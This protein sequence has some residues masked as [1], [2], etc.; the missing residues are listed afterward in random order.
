[1]NAIALLLTLL[2]AGNTGSSCL[3]FLKLGQG[4]RGA[5]LGES[6]TSLAEDA[7]A[8]YWNP[9]GLAR[10][11]GY[12]F[13]A[14]HQQWF[15]GITDEVG[16]AAIP[17]GPGALGF[18]LVYSGD[19]GF[20]GWTEENEPTGTF[21]T[22]S[23]AL[24]AGYGLTV[25]DKYQVGATVKGLMEDLA[26]ARGTGGAVDVGFIGHP[27]SSLGVGLAARHLGVVSYGA[28]TEQLPT[29]FAAGA[30]YHVA[31]FT[32]TIDV[33]VPLA[34]DPNVRVGVEYAPIKQA[35]LRV[36]YRSGPTDLSGLGFVSGLTAGLGF[37]VGSFG[38]D[39][40]L[41]PYGRLGLTHRVGLRYAPAP[42][43]K[44]KF[45]A[46]ALTVVDAETQRPVAAFLTLSGARDTSLTGDGLRLSGLEPVDLRVKAITSGYLPKEA[47]IRV[48][49]GRELPFVVALDRVK[50]GTVK[51]GLYDAGTKEH[52]GGR[53]V[54]RGPVLGEE[55]IK[56][57]PGTYQLRNLPAGDY[58]VGITGPSE[59]YIPQ[60][61]TLV[62]TGGQV[63]ERDFYLARKRQ[64]IVLDGVNFETGKADILPQFA[65]VLDRAGEI[66]KGSPTIKVELAGHTD[67]REINTREFP[68]N[69][70]LSQARAD[71]VRTYLIDKF[72]VAPDRLTARGYADTQPVGPNDTEAGM[73]KN[74]RT[75]FRILEQ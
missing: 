10:I 20:E 65:T 28:G 9:A 19:R 23:A 30:N 37:T 46:V 40:A 31:G 29:E 55:A 27:W 2:S 1:M 52:I 69:W 53:I 56:P 8:I 75:E 44:P 14:S 48:V 66:L 3:P 34:D 73:A 61:C 38:L 60:S 36:G 32:G 64:T 17:F 39:Y 15:T 25:F 12:Q 13:A 70:K 45:G 11:P 33:A 16:H 58:R 63:L 68:D 41:V 49:A 62:V 42:P 21:N 18:G 22:W 35:A 71:A 47:A 57:E 74:R 72:G 26:A 4:P 50:Y 54:Y 51:G 24:S 7:S 43:E 6:Y 5:A 59:D 67:P